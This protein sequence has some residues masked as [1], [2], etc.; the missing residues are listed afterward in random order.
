MKNFLHVIKEMKRDCRYF[1]YAN[2][3]MSTL[4]KATKYSK[5]INKSIIALLSHN[6][7]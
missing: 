4:I 2:F 5:N 7:M 1:K 6:R 3:V